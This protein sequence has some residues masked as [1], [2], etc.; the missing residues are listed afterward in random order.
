MRVLILVGT[1]TGVGLLT[2]L[3]LALLDDPRHAATGTLAA[4]LCLIPAVGTLLLA[5]AVGPG[6]PDATTTVILVGIGLR[7]VGVTAG[8]FLLD[9][10]VTAA[11]IGRERFAGWAVFFY[12]MTLTAESVLVLRPGPTPPAD[13]P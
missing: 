5:G 11:G 13:P 12:L 8:V 1:T 10:A 2:V 3:P 6:D 4:A 9:G 7:F